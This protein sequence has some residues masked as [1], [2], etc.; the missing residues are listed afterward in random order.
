[1]LT[2]K[3]ASQAGKGTKPWPLRPRQC[4]ALEYLLVSTC[5]SEGKGP[6]AVPSTL[7]GWQVLIL[8]SYL[9]CDSPYSRDARHAL[10][11]SCCQDS[12]TPTRTNVSLDPC[13]IRRGFM[14]ASDTCEQFSYTL[15]EKDA[16]LLVGEPCERLGLHRPFFCCQLSFPRPQQ[17]S[18]VWDSTP[19]G[20]MYV[21]MQSQGKGL[22]LSDKDAGVRGRKV[23]SA[24]RLLRGK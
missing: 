6:S 8:P 5:A 2:G 11:I 23:P 21:C 24:T 15:F 18:S 22:K 17:L 4:S 1:M 13:R 19:R 3:G 14:D 7:S 20:C 16:P 9:C 12:V 10:S